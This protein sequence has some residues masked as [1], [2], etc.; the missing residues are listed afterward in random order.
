M[1]QIANSVKGY[2]HIGTHAAPRGSGS[3]ASGYWIDEYRIWDR[4]H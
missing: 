3:K 4:A 2:A 1:I